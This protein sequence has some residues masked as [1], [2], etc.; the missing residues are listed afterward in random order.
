MAKKYL[1]LFGLLLGLALCMLSVPAHALDVTATR[2]NGDGAA[3]ALTT[4]GTSPAIVGHDMAGKVTMGTGSPT[5]CIITFNR[6][7]LVAPACVVIWAGTPL[8][9]QNYTVTTT[10]ITLV[11]TGTSSNIVFYHCI[12]TPN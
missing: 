11:Q 5:G 12:G 4:C 10:A 2:L 6:V 9:A 7:W 1:A 3:P 8:A